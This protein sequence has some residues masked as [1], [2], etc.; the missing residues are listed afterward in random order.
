MV[1]SFTWE[2]MHLEVNLCETF[3]SLY[4]LNFLA[5]DF[6]ERICLFLMPMKYQPDRP[7]IRHVPIKVIHCFT[8]FQIACLALLWTVKSIKQ[9]SILFPIMVS[10]I[11]FNTTN[12]S[13]W[14]SLQ[15][16]LM[17]VVRKLMEYAFSTKH[18]FYL[19]TP[20]PLLCGTPPVDDD[21]SS[22]S[23]IEVYPKDRR[24]SKRYSQ[25]FESFK[26][27]R[28]TSVIDESLAKKEG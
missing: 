19:D 11:M 17:I 5:L 7:Y 27:T 18:L 21:V 6:F 13:S 4:Q 2:S 8:A 9:I 25:M 16:L 14:T 22:E 15:L 12:K 1:F 3:L 28:Q 10:H 26:T 20:M 24:M 23:S